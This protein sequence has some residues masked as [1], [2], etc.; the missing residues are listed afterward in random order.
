MPLQ[1]RVTPF[2]EI[3]ALEARGT[4]MGNRGRLHDDHRRIVRFTQVPRWLAC[5]LEFRGRKRRVMRPGYYTELFFLDEATALSAGHRPCAEC[6]SRDYRR[7]RSFWETLFGGPAPAGTIDA[8]LDAERR[9]GNVK[10][11]YRA[12]LAGLPDGTFVA[13][14][15][16]AWLVSGDALFA[17]SPRGYTRRRER[18]RD[19]NVDVLTPRSI[20]A[21]LAAGYQ[22]DVHA[23]A[24]NA[25]LAE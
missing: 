18:P 12:R 22:P 13:I 11:T 19:G 15:G 17:W 23:S 21:V 5:V 25:P 2:G 6:R 4:M 1:N 14:G 10:R 8:R 7:F 16:D 20:V 3:V 24:G 9:D